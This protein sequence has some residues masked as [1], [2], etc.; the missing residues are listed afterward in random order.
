LALEPAVGKTSS[1]IWRKNKSTGLI[2]G[3]NRGKAIESYRKIVIE[4][5]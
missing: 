1:T 3:F 4:G 2:T 5:I